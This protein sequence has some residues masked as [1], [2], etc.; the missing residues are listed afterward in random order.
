MKS[1]F[2]LRFHFIQGG[3]AFKIKQDYS[4]STVFQKTLSG[5]E[6]K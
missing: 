2:L 4:S 3:T 5:S 1:V 6:G